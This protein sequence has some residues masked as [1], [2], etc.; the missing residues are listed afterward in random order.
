MDEIENKI[1]ADG[2]FQDSLKDLSD[3]EKNS[4][5]EARRK[6]I[7]TEELSLSKKNKELAD[8]YKTRAEKAEAENKTKGKVET[9][10]NEGNLSPKD[11]YALMEAK[12]PQDDVEDITEY[13]AFK[14]ITVTEALKSNIVKK[15]LEEKAEFRRTAN[16]TATRQTRQTTKVDANEIIGNIKTKG[17]E[18]VP[19]QGSSE[20]EELFWSRRGGRRS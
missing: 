10:S 2:A 9:P 16:A 15:M 13:A 4:L 11:L 14:K 20:A 3:E 19:N 5:I 12:V 17:E 6:E 7:I 18:A 8:N 1:T